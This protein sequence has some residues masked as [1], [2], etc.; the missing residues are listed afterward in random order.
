MIR[1]LLALGLCVG[2]PAALA[3]QPFDMS[4][5]LHLR[6]TPATPAAAEPAPRIVQPASPPSDLE[7]NLLPQS[8]VRFEG[9]VGTRTFDFYLT[10]EQAASPASL[11]LSVLNSI[12]VAPEYS[13][14]TVSINETELAATPIEYATGP[15]EIEIDV[16]Q[17]ILVPGRNRIDLS[18]NQRHRTD[19][20]VSS[21][22]ELWTEIHSTGTVLNLEGGEL[23]PI[24]ELADL[25]AVGLNAAGATELRFLVPQIDTP[26]ARTAVLRLVQYLALALKS[27]AVEISLIED[28]ETMPVTGALTVVLGT[29]NALPQDVAAFSGQAN[30]GPVAGIVGHDALPNTLM[31]SGPDWPAI[32]VAV[33]S[34]GDQVEAGSGTL[35]GMRVDLA[36]PIPIITGRSSVSLAELGV[37]TIE[38]NGRRYHTALRFA[39]PADFYANMYS[40]AELVLDAAY[41]PAVQ[42]GSQ[43]EIYV[44]GQIATVVPIL[45]T[46][47]GTFR[48]S[49]LRIPMTN[50][51]PGI[52]EMYVETIL[53]TGE[54]EICPPGLS[55]RASARFLFS[56]NSDLA[57]PEFGRIAQYPDLRAL[58]G[59]G[60]P[61]SG[62]A[63]VPVVVGEDALSLQSAMM[64]L[65]RMA[66]SSG[67]VVE[68]TVVSQ[69]ALNPAI[70]ALMIAPM[71]KLSPDLLS[72]GGVVELNG[73]GEVP[74]TGSSE[75]ALER[76]QETAGAPS[77]N[78]IETARDWVADQLNLAPENFWLFRRAD[79]AYVPQSPNA[80]ILSQVYQHEG[81]VWTLL[82][83]P[84]AQAFA[85]STAH[86]VHSDTWQQVGGRITAV[87]AG[88]E[89]ALVL[90]PRHRTLVPTQAMS[91]INVRLI[92]AN[93]LST[94]V[95]GFALLLGI[96]AILL[97]AA[98]S[99]LLARGRRRT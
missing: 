17:G 28:F 1:P 72:R 82:T 96:I 58:A 48:N 70:D 6:D 78:L 16:P 81:G 77:N 68:A 39:L 91:F 55:G 31:I 10:A 35:G 95:L 3:Q 24:T 63:D 76:W 73:Q 8:G 21:T 5:E 54:D 2:A 23:G 87:G 53:L 92:A 13:N 50:F 34:V 62:A 19:C 75:D 90:Q 99:L 80:A 42:P 69:E 27:P 71:T 25:P 74:V 86:L 41:S 9:E 46:D 7:R 22:Y 33:R 11:N 38:F 93:W 52:N 64:L 97:T 88:D 18:A 57:F 65:S 43:L 51:R 60:E 84:N 47:G 30:A 36:D 14:L 61:Y 49:R 98:T 40:E 44:N 37:D 66:L 59:T 83:I 56:A 4:P 12:V 20:S 94:N 79:G 26:Q 29:A 67:R 89:A 45:R 32:D 85:G 15:T